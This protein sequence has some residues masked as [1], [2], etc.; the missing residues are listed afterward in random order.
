M[1]LITIIFFKYYYI[2]FILYYKDIIINNIEVKTMLKIKFLLLNIILLKLLD[3][4]FHWI[5]LSIN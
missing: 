3:F 1:F 4:Y 5:G 2:F